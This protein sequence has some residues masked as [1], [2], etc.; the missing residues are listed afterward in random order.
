MDKTEKL[1]CVYEILKMNG[2]ELFKSKE[3]EGNFAEN[4]WIWSADGG[5]NEQDKNISGLGIVAS[6]R[7]IP[8][9]LG[10]YFHYEKRSL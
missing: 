8:I 3:A 4:K 5:K 1:F 7:W 6:I 2:F 9:V 10:E